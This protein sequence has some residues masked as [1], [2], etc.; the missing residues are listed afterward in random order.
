MVYVKGHCV[1]YALIYIECTFM[2]F[3]ISRRIR[4]PL[5][6]LSVLLLYYNVIVQ[7][8]KQRCRHNAILSPVYCSMAYSLIQGWKTTETRSSICGRSWIIA[9]VAKQIGFQR[10]F[11][12]TDFEIRDT[13]W[14]PNGADVSASCTALQRDGY[15]LKAI[16][17]SDDS[18][19][20]R[21]RKTNDIG[22][23]IVIGET[24]IYY[25]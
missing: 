9:L 13:R 3:I 24:P 16:T 21:K 15:K 11:W 12:N 10:S 20:N 6:S 19:N 5:R 2:T 7:P 4:P 23:I 1:R 25:V 14:R 8:I 22:T 17:C 18:Y